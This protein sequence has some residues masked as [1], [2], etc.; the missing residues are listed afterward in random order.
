MIKAPEDMRLYSGNCL[1]CN[2]EQVAYRN[3]FTDS[4]FGFT[5][6]P[7]FKCCGGRN[8]LMDLEQIKDMDGIILIE[9]EQ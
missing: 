2:S 5:D 1:K 8:I 6:Y 9:K 7:D 3:G 4:P